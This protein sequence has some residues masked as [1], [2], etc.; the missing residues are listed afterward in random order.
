ME[1]PWALPFIFVYT[2]FLYLLYTAVTC[3][4]VVFV[5]RWVLTAS[6]RFGLAAAMGEFAAAV[7]SAYRSGLKST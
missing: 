5:G 6:A 2:A 4:L 1:G 3:L 7:V